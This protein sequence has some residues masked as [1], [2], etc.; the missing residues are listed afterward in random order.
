MRRILNFVKEHNKDVGPKSEFFFR[1]FVQ[2][3]N[4]SFKSANLNAIER[5]RKFAP[6]Q[7]RSSIDQL[8][9]LWGID[10]N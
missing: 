2:S 8:S 9:E 4:K 1:N 3:A 10:L 7:S 5:F 6:K